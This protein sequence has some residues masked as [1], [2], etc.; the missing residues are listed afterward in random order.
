MKVRAL[1]LEEYQE[2]IRD[3]VNVKRIVLG[4]NMGEDVWLDTIITPQL[5]E[6]GVAREF[7]RSVQDFRKSEGCALGEIVALTIRA[8]KDDAVLLEKYR[9]ELEQ[10]TATQ[11]TIAE[12]EMLSISRS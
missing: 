2:L 11:L 6:E 12:G 4:E 5:R 9:A 3:E 8:G 7:I 1:P 10:A